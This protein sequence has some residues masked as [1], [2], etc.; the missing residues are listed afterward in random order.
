MNLHKRCF[1][2][3]CA[4][5]C[6]A[7]GCG[8]SFG[9]VL[10]DF[11]VEKAKNVE[12]VY[13]NESDLKP[14]NLLFSEIFKIGPGPSSSHTIAP[15]K[16]ANHFA[17]LIKALPEKKRAKSIAITLFG[18]MGATGVGHYTHKAIALGLNGIGPET[19][20]Y[21][22]IK[23]T[24]KNSS[25]RIQIGDFSTELGAK[26]FDFKDSR[27]DKNFSDVM[28]FTLLDKDKNPLLSKRYISTG[29]GFISYE[30]M[31]ISAK[32]APKHPYTTAKKL[33]E[34][35][36][37]KSLAKILL[38]NEIAISGKS[39]AQIKA[40]AQKIIN[41]MLLSVENGLKQKGVLE[42]PFT[43]DRKAANMLEWA[44][45]ADENSA[46]LA[47]IDAYAHATSEENSQ[48]GIIV[49]APTAGSAGVI[50]A[51]IKALK[52]HNIS[53]DVLISSLFVSSAVAM[54]AKTHA[55]IAGAD[56][57]C[58]G[59]IGVASAMGAALVSYAL[60]GDNDLAFSAA[61]IALEHHLG[62]T[63]DPV[64][65][66]V[67]VP[68]ISRC[69]MGAV[70]AWNA[71]IMSRAGKSTHGEPVGLDLAIY[72]MNKTGRDMKDSYKETAKGGLALYF[73]Q[74]C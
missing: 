65:G 69:A 70:K 60:F 11:K 6:A 2:K 18:S 73:P 72:T 64:G 68:C 59:E 42:G 74:Q 38:E 33:L 31:D 67:F 8:S 26:D 45:N 30:G 48:G 71:A 24:F 63:C 54:L 57:G 43:I 41:T 61:A 34:L 47:K 9:E 40:Y 28:E 62:L 27:I 23:N 7:L 21:D 46:F 37:G 17:T 58:Q 4:F 16:A 44:K 66:Y 19:C 32:N 10:K 14:I 49:T 3:N 20:E 56:V 22:A 35:A 55:S 15:M 39:E 50:P 13:L 53:D 25:E 51:L 5:G 29:G 1:L 12:P 52:E 36:K